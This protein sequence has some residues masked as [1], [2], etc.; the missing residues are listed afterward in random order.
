M[1]DE[2]SRFPEKANAKS[3]FE[4]AIKSKSEKPLHPLY[5]FETKILELSHVGYKHG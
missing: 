1:K 2:W 3:L 4:E 5:P